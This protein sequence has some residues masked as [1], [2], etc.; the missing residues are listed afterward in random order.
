MSII[1]AEDLE[2]SPLADLHAIASTLGIDGFRRLRKPDLVAAILARQGGTPPASRD[3][4]TDSD[5]DTEASPSGRSRRRRRG[6]TR[7]ADPGDESASA[8]SPA[9]EQRPAEERVVEGV[10]ELL[11]NGSGFVRPDG[12]TDSDGDVYI[13]AAQA[14]RCELVAGDRISGPTRPPRRSER[15]P[16]LIRIDAI[17]G[18]PAAEAVH[19][20]R[21]ED[22]EVDW[23]TQRLAFATG[24]ALLGAIDSKAPFGAGSRVLIT[25]PSRSG[26]SLLLTRIGEALAALDGY[27]VE[28][29]AV[30]VRPEELTEYRALKYFSGVGSTFATSREAQDAAIEQAVERGRRV[31]VRGGNAVLLIDTLDGLSESAARRVLA[32]ARNLRGA[33]SLTIVATAASPLGGETTLIAL[34]PGT[35]APILDEAASGTLRG[36]LLAAAKPK[37][38]PA[39]PRA[40]RTRTRAT[41]PKPD[42]TDA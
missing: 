33:G 40:P 34:A 16:S 7:D 35:A 29:A 13:S 12:A 14:R 32:A 39:K 26:K 4:A 42:A 6:R 24:D 15:H 18:V 10:V 8:E 5:P 41:A 23:P 25:G 38:A 22:I 20:A 11:A 27:E 2:A 37:R 28:L 19:G 1:T 21:I 30:G 36:D 9:K 31:A 17:N 3:T